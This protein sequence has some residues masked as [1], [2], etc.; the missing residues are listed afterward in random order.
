MYFRDTK[1]YNFQEDFTC[2]I[3]IIFLYK[4]SLEYAKNQEILP[5]FFG[6][7]MHKK[8]NAFEIYFE[9]FSSYK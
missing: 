7:T 2:N 6:E 8:P 1:H 4:D 3:Y 5:W 9:L